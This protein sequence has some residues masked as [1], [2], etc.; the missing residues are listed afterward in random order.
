MNICILT[1]RYPY[2]E[3]AGDVVRICNIAR[4]LKT[5]GHKLTLVS[6]YEQVSD[7]NNQEAKELF[8]DQFLIKRSNLESFLYTVL[9]FLLGKPLQCG[10]YW[11][12]RFLK[13]FKKITTGKKYDLYI[14]QLIRMERYLSEAEVVNT[15]IIEMSDALSKTYS[16]AKESSVYS[17]KKYIYQLEK[18]RIRKAEKEI[19]EKYKKVILVSES[20]KTYLGNKKSL[21]VY[22][23]GV[24]ANCNHD[25]EYNPKK[26]VFVGNMRTLQNQDAVV[27]F[28]NNILLQIKRKYLDIVFYVVGAEP[29]NRIKKL[30]DGVNIFVTGYVEKVEEVIKDACLMVAPI[31]IGAGIQNKV[32]MAMAC[33]V[34]VVLSEKIT[35]GIPELVDG[36][37][38]LVARSEQDYIQYCELL[39]ENP[40]TRDALAESGF[41]MV[42]KCYSWSALL[43]GYEDL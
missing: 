39:I 8:D 34:P 1:P 18:N 24:F 16:L 41:K 6:F 29:S 37:N 19:I 33:H 36:E 10:F 21:Y 42:K 5:K 23:N 32:L 2:P 22:T 35:E 40:S 27:Y 20:D 13:I 17:L 14:A 38:C 9:Y 3:A 15:S 4:Y 28:I 11:S 12:P 26:I 7:I 25:G 30:N 43:D 31:R